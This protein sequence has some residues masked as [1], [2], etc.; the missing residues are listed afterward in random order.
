MRRTI[1]NQDLVEE[2]KKIAF[3]KGFDL[4]GTARANDPALGKALEIYKTWIDAKRNAEMEYLSRHFEIKKDPNLFLKNVKSVICVGLLYGENESF[5]NESAQ[6]AKVSLYTRG[7]DYH[8]IM[9]E[10]LALISDELN[11]KFEGEYRTFV[12]AE[13]VL[14]RFWGWRAGLGWVGKNSCLINRKKGSFFFIG[15]IFTT[16]DLES[17]EIHP[18]HCGKCTKCIDACPTEAILSNRT[19]DSNLCIAYHTIENKGVVPETLYKN[20]NQWVAGCDICQ[21]VCPWNDPVTPSHHFQAHHNAYKNQKNE[22]P[23]ILDLIRWSE[24]EFEQELK[25]SAL[26][27]MGYSGWLRNLAIALISSGNSNQKELELVINFLQEKALE[28]KSEKR[29][30]G[31]IKA[32]EALSSHML[33]K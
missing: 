8:K 11:K 18:D 13:A 14:D 4:F 5:K 21:S 15:G 2:I 7:I 10:K 12:D 30:L 24:D 33:K 31:L 25:N 26:S 22:R 6:Q 16:L 32:I 1:N 19:I 29:K 23:A 17:S 9:K 20:F 27:R 3:E 28:I